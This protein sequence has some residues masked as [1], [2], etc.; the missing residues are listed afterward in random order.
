MARSMSKAPVSEKKTAAKGARGTARPVTVLVGT[1]KGAFF[2]KSDAARRKITLSGPVKLGQVVYQMVLD[3][4]D[5]TT[6]LMASATGHMGPTVFRSTDRARTWKE[7]AKPPAF[8]KA[9]DGAVGV[10]R[11]SH[12]SQARSKSRA[13]PWSAI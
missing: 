3:P 4:R 2:L 7:A 8:P 13:V 6:M 5:K 11:R 10:R 1:R 12:F 9:A